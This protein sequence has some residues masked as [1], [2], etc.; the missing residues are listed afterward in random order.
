MIRGLDQDDLIKHTGCKLPCNYRKYDIKGSF[1][2][3]REFGF[4]LYFA[5]KAESVEK[6]VWTYGTE[7]FLA[8]FGGALSLF[9]GF[10]CLMFW[11]AFVLVFGITRKFIGYQDIHNI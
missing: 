7:S 8:E 3:F 4:E 1:L 6:E 11:D 5:S 2:I 9:T 10:S